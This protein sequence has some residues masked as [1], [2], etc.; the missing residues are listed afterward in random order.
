MNKIEKILNEID[1]IVLT[2]EFEF[3]NAKYDEVII[4]KNK[5]NLTIKLEETEKTYVEKINIYGNYITDENVIRNSLIV[6]EGDAYN[7]ILIN[8]SIND[9]KSKNIFVNG[10]E[11]NFAFFVISL[12]KNKAFINPSLFSKLLQ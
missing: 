4:E 11:I 6:D 2:K 8:K 3:I 1:K 7:Q 12:L 9:I 5:I 10:P